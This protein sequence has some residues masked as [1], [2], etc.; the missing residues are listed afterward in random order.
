MYTGLFLAICILTLLRCCSYS[1]NSASD[2][3]RLS[4]SALYCCIISLSLHLSLADS[5]STL[6]QYV[7]FFLALSAKSLSV[8]VNIYQKLPVP[9]KTRSENQR[10]Q[11]FYSIIHPYSTYI[12][13][14][15]HQDYYSP[16]VYSRTRN[17][18]VLV[19]RPPSFCCLYKQ[20][21][22]KFIRISKRQSH[23]ILR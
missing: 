18:A 5:S 1:L 14:M 8:T 23:D 19:V 2:L 4:H 7:Y 3:A 13:T 22:G 6:W 9:L 21:C 10:L 20:K 16:H 12:Y 11:N 17:S 15:S